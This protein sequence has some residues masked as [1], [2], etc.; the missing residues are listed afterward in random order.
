MAT[1]VQ[2]W[3]TACAWV[4]CGYHPQQHPHFTRGRSDAVIS[5]TVTSSLIKLSLNVQKLLWLVRR[6]EY[7]TIDI[8]ML[9]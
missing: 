9:L 1:D 7:I 3:H 4:K 6:T 5:H 2:I 8:K